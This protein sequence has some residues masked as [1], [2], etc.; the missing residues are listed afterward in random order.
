MRIIA[1]TLSVSILLSKSAFAAQFLV[2]NEV[3]YPGVVISE[4]KA[5]SL[6]SCI[7]QCRQTANCAAFTM[8]KSLD[9]CKLMKAAAPNVKYQSNKSRISFIV[10]KE[11]GIK[12]VC[13]RYS[14]VDHP[15]GDL[16]PPLQV[17][18]RTKCQERCAALTNCAGYVM[19]NENRLCILKERLDKKT[20]QVSA[21]R[22]LYVCNR[23]Y[24]EGSSSV[25]AEEVVN[26]FS[27]TANSNVTD[28]M[29]RCLE[30]PKC[31]KFAL[32]DANRCMLIYS[33]DLPDPEL[34]SISTDPPK[35]YYT[36][37][38]II[39]TWQWLRQPECRL[40][41][42]IKLPY[43]T[44][45]LRGIMHVSSR[46]ASNECPFLCQR[47]VSCAMVE[48]NK[49][50]S[51]CI[52]YSHF[53]VE[54][55]TVKVGPA[56]TK[57][58]VTTEAAKDVDAYVCR[59]PGFINAKSVRCQHD[60]K[61][62]LF[63]NGLLKHLTTEE[64]AQLADSDYKNAPLVD[65]SGMQFGAALVGEI[66]SYRTIYQ[67]TASGQTVGGGVLAQPPLRNVK[68]I[69]TNSGLTPIPDIQM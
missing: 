14:N 45:L 26:I 13:T 6:G 31:S 8:P 57:F 34:T 66:V 47:T 11:T 3:E 37:F 22:D 20:T 18:S 23:F 50:E 40:Y 19:G 30:N 2:N 55:I 58:A 52:I 49:K 12:D 42:S 24:V 63:G 35:D 28:C 1:I 43:I 41:K 17:A 29:R 59:Y 5:K 7:A 51:S 10:T 25:P 36:V 61:L 68:T 46:N 27:K 38:S 32:D 56:Q 64:T 4:F 33:S 54:L 67:T 39:D 60:Q 16:L 48:I 21:T 65:C 62:Y 15:T 44:M 9:S 53:P 69:S